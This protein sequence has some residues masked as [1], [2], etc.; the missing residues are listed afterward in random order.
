MY[1]VWSPRQSTPPLF[2]FFQ[3]DVIWSTKV[4]IEATLSSLGEGQDRNRWTGSRDNKEEAFLC[5][6][7]TDTGQPSAGDGFGFPTL[8]RRLDYI[9][10]PNLRLGD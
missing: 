7:Y 9:A 8:S 2:L 10:L 4:C 5:W 1:I 6:K 3:G